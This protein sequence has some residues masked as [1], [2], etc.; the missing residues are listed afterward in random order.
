VKGNYL[1]H[2]EQR[3]FHHLFQTEPWSKQASV[4]F[5]EPYSGAAGR[6]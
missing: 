5:M 4:R 1:F 6:D 2:Y 3:A